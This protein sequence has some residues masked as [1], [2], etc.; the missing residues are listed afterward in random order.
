MAKSAGETR[1][2]LL[3]ALPSVDQLL[4]RLEGNGALSGVPRARVVAARLGRTR[5][6]R[7]RLARA[8]SARGFDADVIERVLGPDDPAD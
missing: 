8:L 2:A 1:Q 4:K 6:S 3:R 5:P 7:A